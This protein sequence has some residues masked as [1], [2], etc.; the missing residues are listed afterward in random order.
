MVAPSE[1]E[2]EPITKEEALKR[3]LA[4]K[5]SATAAA[6]GPQADGEPPV[7]KRKEDQDQAKT[8]TSERSGH[9]KMKQEHS[10]N[11]PPSKKSH[12]ALVPGHQNT[13]TKQPMR[14]PPDMRLVTAMAS[15]GPTLVDSLQAMNMGPSNRK[16][17]LQTLTTRDMVMIPDLFEESSGFV[18]P[19]DPWEKEGV[20][21]TIYQRL[22]EEIH[23]AGNHEARGGGGGGG[24]GRFQ[25]KCFSTDQEGLFKNDSNGLFKAWH[26]TTPQA[27]GDGLAS[28][29][30]GNGHLIVNDRDV[31]WQQAQRRGEAPMYTA[32]RC[33]LC[34]TRAAPR[35]RDAAVSLCISLSCT[36]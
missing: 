34:L 8:V 27:A 17:I 23:H 7:G 31:R 30:D 4:R 24:G 14:R 32:V 5:K 20:S 10:D 12:F 28:G 9:K 25:D 33:V 21:K 22:V 29:K 3:F 19:P 13:T 16:T 1:T 11:Y 35:L 26:K 18:I 15:K 6:D 2:A 36:A